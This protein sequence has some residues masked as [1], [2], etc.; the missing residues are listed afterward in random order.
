MTTITIPFTVGD[1]VFLSHENTYTPVE[2]Y[3]T[4]INIC[5]LAGVTDQPEP[6]YTVAY[7]PINFK[8]ET[9]AKCRCSFYKESLF[10]TLEEAVENH[11][12]YVVV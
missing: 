6:E 12:K 4:E 7:M 9:C 8:G 5:L 3:I 1:R 11:K 10:H 2:G